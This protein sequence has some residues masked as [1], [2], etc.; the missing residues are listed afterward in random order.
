[1]KKRKQ[2]NITLE[3]HSQNN[4]DEY[5]RVHNVTPQ[6]LF[7]L[8]AQRVIDDDILERRADLMTLASLREIEAGL[9][10]PI[11]DLLV[12]IEEDKQ[13]GEQMLHCLCQPKERR[14]L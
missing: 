5:C 1:M 11:D 8:G 2:I 10:A 6:E 12:M 3:E 7:K 9:D 4:V 14:A 13:I